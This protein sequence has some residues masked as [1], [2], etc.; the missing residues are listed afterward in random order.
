MLS[1]S[2]LELTSN[3][4]PCQALGVGRARLAALAKIGG[5]L[6]DLVVVEGSIGKPC[7]V[8]QYFAASKGSCN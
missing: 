2:S 4:S 5:V 8:S 6:D 7:V 1:I 3:S